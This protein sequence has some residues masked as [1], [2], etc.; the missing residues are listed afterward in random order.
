[1]T[2]QAQKHQH[3]PQSSPYFI[4]KNSEKINVKNMI[5]TTNKFTCQTNAL[6]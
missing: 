6:K 3:F 1:M 4:N 2:T 5:Q